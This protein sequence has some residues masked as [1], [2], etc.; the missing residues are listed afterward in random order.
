MSSAAE[1]KV[2]EL[3]KRYPSVRSA[4]MPALYI[5]QEELGWLSDSA[6]RWVA[7]RLDLPPSHVLEV[8]TFYTMY[9]KQPVGRYHV[10]VCRTLS[11]MLCGARGLTARLRERLGIAP[12]EI[13][14]DGMWSYE[15]VE[16]LGSCGTAPMV[17]INDVFFE[18]LTAESLDA[19]MDRIEAE[20][21]DLR[22]STVQE[23]LGAGLAGVKKSQI[24]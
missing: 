13:T 22:Y 5:A 18:N 6:I 20:Q 16:C 3:K 17:E 12:G 19:L 14:A 2:E 10:Q 23:E 21:P 7:A 1:K 8:A 4:V 9:Y 15:E 24:L 11:C